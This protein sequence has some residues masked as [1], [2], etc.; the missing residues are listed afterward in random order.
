M[1]STKAINLL[2]S[3]TTAEV[4]NKQIALRKLIAGGLFRDA[5]IVSKMSSKDYDQIL[6]N[7]LIEMLS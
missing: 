1:L 5:E 3:I 6:A 4:D 2:S 7:D